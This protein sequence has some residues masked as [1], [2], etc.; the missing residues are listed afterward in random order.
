MLMGNSATAKKKATAKKTTKKATAKKSSTK[1]A[2]KKTS[3][4][5]VAPV[6]DKKK[7]T[8]SDVIIEFLAEGL[9]AVQR[10]I[11][12]NSVTP[13]VVRRA[14]DELM[15]THPEKGELFAAWVRQDYPT[16]RGKTAPQLGEVREFKAQ[17]VDTKDKKTKKVIKEGTPFSRIP[18]EPIGVKR[19][20]HI[21][22]EFT[23]GDGKLP[24]RIVIYKKPGQD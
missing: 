8:Y 10:Y 2:S 17:Q 1:K 14:S 12:A 24:D 15:G 21:M 3:P 16:G 22:V 6:E 20:Q 23:A 18:L 11:K 9:N 4:K 19:G 5:K 13:A 7:I